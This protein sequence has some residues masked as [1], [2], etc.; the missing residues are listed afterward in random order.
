MDILKNFEI[1]TV[2]KLKIANNKFQ[3]LKM[4]N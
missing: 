1:E 4:E 2:R 3:G